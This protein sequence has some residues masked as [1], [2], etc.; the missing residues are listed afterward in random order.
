MS[1]WSIVALQESHI[2]E[3]LAIEKASF[4]QPWQ[5]NYFLSELNCNAAQDVV[6]LESR[7]EQIIAYACMR[8][9]LDE[10]HVLK[11]AVAHP[12]RRRGVA[13]WLMR[14]GFQRAREH[15]MKTVLLEVRRSNHAARRLYEKL[16]FQIVGTRL[17]YY[18]DTGEDALMMIK[19]L[20]EAQ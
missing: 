11:I 3:I 9:L 19:T 12:W 13:T 1:T 14:E 17:R 8:R 4:R 7:N 18:P 20:E 6:A 10:M 5:R 16:G 15:R 2:D